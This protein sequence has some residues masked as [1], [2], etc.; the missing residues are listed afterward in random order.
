MRFFSKQCSRILPHIFISG[1]QIAKDRE[2]LYDNKI[3]RILNCAGTILPCHHKADSTLTYYTLPLN[4]TPEEQ[5]SRYFYP[6]IAMMEE[7]KKESQSIL[8]HCHQGVSRS[9]T[10]VV[11]YIMFSQGLSYEQAFH[12]VREARGVGQPNIGFMC[13]LMEWDKRRKDSRKKK[14]ASST[15]VYLSFPSELDASD[16]FPGTPWLIKP[17][18]SQLDGKKL[19]AE[20]GCI[21][22]HTAEELMVRKGSQCS[23]VTLEGAQRHVEHLRRFEN[24][25]E[26]QEVDASNE[27][28]RSALESAGLL[29]MC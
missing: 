2:V 19:L 13:Q 9:V 8:V 15:H 21:V 22:I 16:S 7:G 28:F 11:A 5:I 29:S 1:E 10:F 26:S 27:A 25:P 18:L 20:D 23:N 4:D 6:V 12:S 14:E 3:S 24:A 17:G